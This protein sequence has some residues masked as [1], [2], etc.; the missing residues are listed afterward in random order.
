MIIEHAER[1][2][3]AQLHQLRGR[4]GRGSGDS[5]CVLVASEKLAPGEGMQTSDEIEQASIAM[6]RLRTL[7]ATSDGFE[8]AKVDMQIRGT[9]E[10]PR[11]EAIGSRPFAPCGFNRGCRHRRAN[12]A[13]CGSGD[14]RRPAAPNAAQRRHEGGISEALPRCRIVFAYWLREPDCAR[15]CPTIACT[16][17]HSLLLRL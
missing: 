1:F 11:A 12:D 3:L 5:V 16:R 17:R 6:E 15:C 9:G 2:G 14:R 7:V 8:I 10:V 13:G 4:V